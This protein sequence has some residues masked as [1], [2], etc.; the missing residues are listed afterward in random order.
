MRSWALERWPEGS[1]VDLVEDLGW[2][3]ADARRERELAQV[4][5]A[6]QAAS[7]VPL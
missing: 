2:M 5:E 1:V 4:Q 3:K 6:A 7:V